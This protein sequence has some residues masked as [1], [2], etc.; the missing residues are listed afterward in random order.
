[1]LTTGYIGDQR[2][3]LVARYKGIIIN[4]LVVRGGGRIPVIQVADKTDPRHFKVGRNVIE[5][6]DRDW[7][8][9][10]E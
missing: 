1:M 5:V 10:S 9:V 3:S 6:L 2:N 8:K 7:E 4:Q